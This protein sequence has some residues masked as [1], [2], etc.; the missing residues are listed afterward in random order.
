MN[1]VW[2]TGFIGRGAPLGADL[3]LIIELGLGV[4][5]LGGMALARRGW[6][7]GHGACQS[8]VFLMVV[9]LTVVWMG[10]SLHDN[11]GP[12]LFAGDVNRVNVAVGAHIV[13]GTVALLLGAYVVLVAGTPLV[14]KRL[15][16]DD[17]K[18]W[19]RTLL[20]L[21]WLAILLGALTYWLATS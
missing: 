3:N 2:S 1:G 17:Y 21:W 7:R 11:Y 18:P 5:L 13:I 20:A 10:P 4:A 19:M 16:F 9:L 8:A 15:R 6:Y 14:P 12:S